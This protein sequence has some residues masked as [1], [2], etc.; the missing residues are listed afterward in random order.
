MRFV[1]STVLLLFYIT[2]TAAAQPPWVRGDRDQDRG[3]GGDDRGRYDRSS[4]YGSDREGSSRGSDWMSR[5]DPSSMLRRADKNGD[6]RIDPNEID[7]R[8]RGFA[9]RMLEQ[10]GFD[11]KKPI[12]LDALSKKYQERR[13]GEEKKEDKEEDVSKTFGIPGFNDV[14]AGLPP[15][16]PDFF[17]DPNS[18]VLLAGSIETRYEKSILDQVNRT[19]RYY[20]RNKDGVLDNEEIRR[21]RFNSPPVEESDLD[22]DGKL[23]KIELAERYV[24]RSGGKGRVESGTKKSSSSSSSSDR[25]SRWERYRKEREEQAKKSAEKSKSSKSTSSRS[26]S[27]RSS[28]SSSSRDDKIVSYAKSI[29]SKY[30]KNEDK[31]LDRKEAE[32][33]R[34]LPSGADKNKDGKISLEELIAGFGGK[35]SSS[36][37]ESASRR[38]S[39]SSNPYIVKSGLDRSNEADRDFQELDKNVDG[40]IQMHEFSRSWSDEVG[41]NFIK[42]DQDNNGVVTISEWSK[43][44]GLKSSRSSSSR[45]SR[46][47][48]RG[49]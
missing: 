38:R 25:A 13:K 31:I 39:S 37:R 9:G 15:L 27:S 1:I 49:D 30:D 36:S 42:L 4:R 33:I 24:S 46:S 40:L 10:Y 12:S 16:V 34:S 3:R 18:P 21:G 44:G 23:S 41:Q 8:Y 14:D 2:S 35:S 19:L 32:G 47:Q 28:S 17:L 43:G 6:G 45:S 11:P 20:D 48:S 5:I 22:R 29:L 7:E 26:S